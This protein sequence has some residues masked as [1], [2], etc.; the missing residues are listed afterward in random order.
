MGDC[1]LDLAW[2]WGDHSAFIGRRILYIV[3]IKVYKINL[4]WPH[5]NK[6]I[7]RLHGNSA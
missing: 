2:G 7:W 5:S 4:G 1:S 3:R 6:R